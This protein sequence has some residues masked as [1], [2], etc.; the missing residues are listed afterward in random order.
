MGCEEARS[1]LVPLLKLHCDIGT[2]TW[3]CVLKGI[4]KDVDKVLSTKLQ[5]QG[6]GSNGLWHNN[7]L[8]GNVQLTADSNLCPSSLLPEAIWN[9]RSQASLPSSGSWHF[10]CLPDVGIGPWLSITS[11]RSVTEIPESFQSHLPDFPLHLPPRHT[12][13]S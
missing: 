1:D 13:G 8:I 3:R 6:G 9:A 10:H 5:G 7:V 4:W 11:V 12:H 2:G